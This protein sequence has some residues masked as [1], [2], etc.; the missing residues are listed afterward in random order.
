MN[1]QEGILFFV[2]LEKMSGMALYD[3]FPA[4]SGRLS[5]IGQDKKIYNAKQ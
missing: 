1:W 3:S 2:H 5:I 4:V